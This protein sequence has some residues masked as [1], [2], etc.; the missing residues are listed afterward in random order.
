MSV[1]TVRAN[2]NS[3]PFSVTGGTRDPQFE[4]D[5]ISP[6]MDAVEAERTEI[7]KDISKGSASNEIRPR[8]GI[9]RVVPRS[10]VVAAQL[11]DNGTSITLPT[12]HTSRFQQGHL[13]L[14]TRASDGVT[15]EVWVNDDP[16]LTAVP[17]TRIADDNY[18]FEVGDRVTVIG[19][20]MPQGS[21]FP[22]APVA[23]GEQY[24]NEW[25]E[26]SKHLEHTLQGDKTPSKDNPSGSLQTRDKLQ[27]SKQIKQDLNYSVLL[28]RR[29]AGDPSPAA[30][31]P[32]R[33]GGIFQMAELS[34]NVFTVGGP[35]V[36]LTPDALSFVQHEMADKYKDGVPANVWVMSYATKQILNRVLAPLRLYAGESGTSYDNR[37]ETF[38]TDEGPIKFTWMR[39]FPDG[40]ILGYEP[41]KLEYFPFEGADWKEK[42]FPTKGFY[43]WY[44]IGGIYSLRAKNIP[45]MFII[46]GFDTNIG[47]YPNVLRPATFLA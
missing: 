21:D 9:H 5:D 27:I 24:T 23:R 38:M 13:L 31:L 45:G 35:N 1:V 41:K 29:S 47:H 7:L 19:I 18:Q 4:M 14:L 20:A 8:W 22:L 28:G 42:E 37:W 34:G 32:S 2:Q 33:M 17:I 15:E 16:A 3:F 40:V 25:Q 36:L 43:S 11:A 26:F 46:K 10:S 44:G 39:D 30:P 12:G 6:W